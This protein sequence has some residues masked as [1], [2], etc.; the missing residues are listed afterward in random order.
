MSAPASRATPTHLLKGEIDERRSA[1][2]TACARRQNELVQ[3]GKLAALG[4][5]SAAIAHGINQPLTAI[6][7]FVASTRV[8]MDRGDKDASTRNLDLDQQSRQAHGR[9]HRASED[10]RPQ[11]RGRDA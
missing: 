5:M 9:D 2:R 7:T 1:R 10:V 8:L 3:A 6:R 11:E 4:Q